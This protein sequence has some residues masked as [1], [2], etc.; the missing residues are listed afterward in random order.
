MNWTPIVGLIQGLND[1]KFN[2]FTKWTRKWSLR[3]NCLPGS[4]SNMW[5]S[6]GLNKLKGGLGF[7]LNCFVL[8]LELWD[9]LD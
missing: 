8:F 3:P 6:L 7:G 9:N 4:Y 5:A 1:S 2:C